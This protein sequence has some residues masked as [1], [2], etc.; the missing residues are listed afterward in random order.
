MMAVFLNDCVR[1]LI[2]SFILMRMSLDAAQ[3]V[4][5]TSEIVRGEPS[6]LTK[7]I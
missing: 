1:I 7:S 4:Q 2:M 5:L 6:A 3:D